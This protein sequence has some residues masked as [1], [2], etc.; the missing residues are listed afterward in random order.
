[1]RIYVHREGDQQP[2][3]LETASSAVLGEILANGEGEVTVAQLED[4]DV[5]LDLAASVQGAG[6]EDRA[7]I[8]VGSRE[9]VAVEVL[10]NGETRERE[11]SPASTVRRAFR[12]AVGKHGFDLSEVDAI[13][14]TLAL[15]ADGAVPAEDIH[16][17]S[18]DSETPG[19]ICFMLIAK[20][21]F[22]G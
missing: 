2:D 15:C 17:G 18:L 6:I 22:E 20:H 9:R 7:H 11:F 10:Y 21:R 12:W 16:L 4:T 19:R 1:M 14:H 13:E 3:A 8:F 5:L